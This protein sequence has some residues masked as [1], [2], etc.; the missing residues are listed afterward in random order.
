MG[1][2]S[3]KIGVSVNNILQCRCK[4]LPDR[5]K[6]VFNLMLIIIGKWVYASHSQD[7]AYDFGAFSS[8]M[9]HTNGAIFVIIIMHWVKEGPY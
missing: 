3:V 2:F 6:I 4:T 1:A 8:S 9:E 5:I 7:E